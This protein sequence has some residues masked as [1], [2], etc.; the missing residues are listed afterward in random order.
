MNKEQFDSLPVYIKLFKKIVFRL[1]NFFDY[2][3]TSK[4]NPIYRS[5]TL[6]VGL[7]LVLII[8]GLYLLFFYRLSDPYNSLINIQNNVPL[9]R[10]VRSI[11]RYATD[12][13]I[14]VIIFH[15]IQCLAQ[16]KTW[17]P[18]ILAWISGIFLLIISFIAGWTGYVII[19]DEFSQSLLEVGISLI[20]FIPFIGEKMVKAFSDDKA[21]SSSFML[22]NLFLHIFLPL[23]LMAMVWFHTIKLARSLW[24]PPRAIIFPIIFFLIITSFIY[25]VQ[26]FEPASF[27]KILDKTK[28]DLFLGFFIPIW[29]G[30]G[31]IQM[32]IILFIFIL[33]A[34]AIPL[35]WK[36]RNKE[37]FRSSR[38][39]KDLCLGCKQC[40]RDC[41]YD[42]ITMEPREG[43]IPLY[44]MV[45][46]DLCVSCG[47]CVA[48]CD[49]MAIGPKDRTANEQLEAIKLKISKL[50]NKNLKEKFAIII[51]STNYNSF[52][53][54][55]DKK[56]K[57]LIL[58]Q[59]PCASNLHSFSIEEII[60]KFK[61]IIIWTCPSRNCE[62]RY[63]VELL[64]E[65]IFEYRHP[66]PSRRIDR[67][68][69]K[70]VSFSSIEKKKLFKEIDFFKTNIDTEEII[71]NQSFQLRN[72]ILIP[73]A[74][75]VFLFFIAK[76]SQVTLIGNKNYSALKISTNLESHTSNVCHKPT[77]QEST[78]SLL[79]M[80]PQ[81]ICTSDQINYSLE[82]KIEGQIVLQETISKNNNKKTPIIFTKL[83]EVEEGD[84]VVDILI[85]PSN[86]SFSNIEFKEKINFN[87]KQIKLFKIDNNNILIIN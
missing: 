39:D 33:I 60:K 74:S 4:Y 41:P 70:V 38:V 62:S 9:G 80:Q 81:Q 8:T 75:L 22:V 11:H 78:S 68:K 44:S 17:G 14:V 21:I 16:I 24:L 49:D 34:V 27:L 71:N 77:K 42:A 6:A 23:S 84:K 45:H 40:Q 52:K 58:F 3:Y 54:I 65:R 28:G 19:W 53:I 31:V 57:D 76:L 64:N 69:I 18:H 50:E 30:L 29:D 36:P 67:R 43:K 15:I 5:G 10:L 82:L 47:A 63:G 59:I 26:L 1:N 20:G 85:K 7:L 72:Y 56:D 83:I 73:T 55:E 35:F 79:H 13:F 51:C 48:S 37:A 2:I 32:G 66:T 86:P 46:K 61:G 87:K 25:P 12:L